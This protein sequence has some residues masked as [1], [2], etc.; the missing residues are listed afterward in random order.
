MEPPR[1]ENFYVVGESDIELWTTNV[2]KLS[3][4]SHGDYT[5]NLGDLVICVEDS[6]S[7][8]PQDTKDSS[9]GTSFLT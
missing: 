7:L 9:N 6:V 1:E 5:T 8:V 4:D 3:A 2:W